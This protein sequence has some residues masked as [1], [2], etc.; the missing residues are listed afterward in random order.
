ML[1][2]RIFVACGM[3]ATGGVSASR[4]AIALSACWLINR[5][6]ARVPPPSI[7]YGGM[8]ITGDVVVR[9]LFDLRFA[10]VGPVSGRIVIGHG[11][12][13]GKYLAKYRDSLI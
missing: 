6:F 1:L 12:L 7:L 5:A 8:I 13:A 4:I 3:K 10:V 2:V 9:T 11:I